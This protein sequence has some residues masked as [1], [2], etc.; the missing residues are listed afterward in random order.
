MTEETIHYALRKFITTL[1]KDK[2][3]ESTFCRKNMESLKIDTDFSNLFLRLIKYKIFINSYG[4]YDC[5]KNEILVFDEKL[6]TLFHELLHM[7]SSIYFDKLKISLSGFSIY[8]DA[9]KL[10][11]YEALNEGYTE[12]LNLRYFNEFSIKNDDCYEKEKFAAFIVEDIVGKSLMTNS[13]FKA[14]IKPVIRKLSC[15]G[16]WENLKL[17]LN[18]LDNI[19]ST[20]DDVNIHKFLLTAYQFKLIENL[21]NKN[22]TDDEL[23][24]LLAFY[25]IRF[26]IDQRSEAID[27]LQTK[28]KDKVLKKIRY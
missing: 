12:L 19:E 16:E 26:K 23:I 6:T 10:R 11:K 22:I 18:D 28:L 14:D 15:Y 3:Y 20:P 4:Q 21:I 8:N 13:Y 25:C 7:A 5:A 27:L 1:E 2:D 24:T 9:N 17:F